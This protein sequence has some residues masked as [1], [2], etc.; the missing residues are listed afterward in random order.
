MDDKDPVTE[1]LS[2]A[3]AKL[4]R[5]KLRD[6]LATEA[7]HVFAEL[8]TRVDAVLEERRSGRD[9]RVRPRERI[10]DRRRTA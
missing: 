2:E 7:Q 10:V 4:R 3:E 8:G 5:L 1:A 9:R 6:Q